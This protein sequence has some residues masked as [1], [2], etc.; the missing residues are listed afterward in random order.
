MPR[1]RANAPAER[2]KTA[3]EIM[4]QINDTL[5][6]GSISWLLTLSLSRVTSRPVYCQWT[7]FSMGE[8]PEVESQKCFGDFSIPQKLHCSP[9]DFGLSGRWRSCDAG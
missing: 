9:C 8:F 3:Q 2:K 4:R 1:G 7:Y 6:P 5:G